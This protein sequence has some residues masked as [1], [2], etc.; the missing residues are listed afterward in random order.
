MDGFFTQSEMISSRL[1]VKRPG[2]IDKL[3]LEREDVSSGWCGEYR[4]AMALETL[5]TRIYI[6]A[7]SL[8]HNDHSSCYKNNEIHNEPVGVQRNT[9]ITPSKHRKR[10]MRVSV[11]PATFQTKGRKRIVQ[12]VF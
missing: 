6:P 3:S 4:M 1:L 8:P 9:I 2:L 12:I 7:N 11:A 10:R 5:N